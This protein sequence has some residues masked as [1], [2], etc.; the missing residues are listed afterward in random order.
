MRTGR[1]SQDADHDQKS[2]EIPTRR[3]DGFRTHSKQTMTI[4]NIKKCGGCGLWFPR[5]PSCFD[6]DADDF[7]SYCVECKD[8]WEMTPDAHFRRMRSQLVSE[9]PLAWAAWEACL[10]G[11]FAEF[12]RKL[13]DQ[14]GVCKH[15]GAGLREWQVKG[16]NLDRIDNSDRTLHTPQNTVFA[17]RPCNMT[18]G[19]KRWQAW[20][21]RVA[22][23]VEEY[24]WGRVAWGEEDDRF[25]RTI[26]RMCSHLAAPAP[27]LELFG[28][29][30]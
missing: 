30:A 2:V 29:G 20:R 26:R 9:E 25:T 16:H 28:G 22:A 4:A 13:R 15:C 1:P 10:G 21:N 23:I 18:R 27:Q 14:H 5:L 17:C 11:A 12:L 19:R 24:G 6:A 3:P 8:K 7:Q